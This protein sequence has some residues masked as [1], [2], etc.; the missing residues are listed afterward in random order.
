VNSVFYSQ[1]KKLDSLK[2]SYNNTRFSDTVRVK[3]MLNFAREFGKINR[4]SAIFHFKKALTLIEMKILVLKADDPEIQFY[5]IKKGSAIYNVGYFYFLQGNFVKAESLWQQSL[6]VR[7]GNNDKAG[8]AQSMTGLGTIYLNQGKIEQAMNY[9]KR[10]LKIEE[11]LGNKLAI[12]RLMNN[13]ALVYMN[14]GLVEKSLECHKKSLK[15]NEEIGD[16]SAIGASLNNIAIIYHS[17]KQID[18][19]IDW[20]TRSLKITEEVNDKKGIATALSNLA[21]MYR[22]QHKIEKAIEHDRR[23]LKLMEEIDDKQGIATSLSSLGQNYF[24]EGKLKESLESYNKS[25]KIFEEIGNL[26]R[27]SSALVAMSYIYLKE[28]KYGEAV[29]FADKGFKLSNETGIPNEIGSAAEVMKDVYTAINKPAEALKMYELYIRMLDSVNNE[30]NKNTIL[31]KQYEIEFN[32]KEREVMLMADTERKILVQKQDADKKKLAIIVISVLFVLI[33][34]S[35]FSIIIL[36]SLRENKKTSEIMRRQKQ[37]VE[38][39]QKEV[40]DSIQYAKRLQDAILPAGNYWK[41][42]LAD[43]FVL[44]KPKDIVAGDF[45]WMEKVGDLLLFAVGDCT[46]HGVPGAMV[47]VVCSNALNRTVLEFKITDPGKILDKTRELVISTFEKSDKEVKDGMDISLCCYDP[48]T[49]L[50][51]WAGANNALWYIKDGE[52]ASI[53]AN[54]QPI[55]KFELQKPF[56]TNALQLNK[57]DMLFL[58]SDGYSDQFGGPKGKKFKYKQLTDLLLANREKTTTALKELLDKTFEDWKGLN[59]Q[60]DDVCIVGVRI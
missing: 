10:S 50:L 7:K 48:K 49:K 46:G 22:E 60:V 39:K 37:L 1:N 42:N 13:M 59:E 33:L 35:I 3:S 14:K 30:E 34:V 12:S 4:D 52:L 25:L 11:E 45:Y 29:K 53:K 41:E 19:A 21:L 26:Q 18:D 24:E 5:N 44:Y 8:I 40:L 51:Q 47:S 15:Y 2:A 54:K 32:S 27:T 43:S 31:K 38:A 17:Q 23:S 58:I 28:K 56:T 20:F 55:G 9:Y 57:S 36:K 6:S 16:K